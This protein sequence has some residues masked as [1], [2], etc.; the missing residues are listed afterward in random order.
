MGRRTVGLALVGPGSRAAGDGVGKAKAAAA[1]PPKVLVVTSTAGRSDD[2][3]PGR[4]Q[5]RRRRRRVHGHRA[6][7]GRGRRGVHAREPRDLPRGRVPQHGHREPAD[8]RAARRSSR[9]T[10]ARAAVRRHRLGDRDRSVMAVPDRRP[11]HARVRPHRAADGH[12][13]G[14]RPRPR[15]EQVAPAC[16]GS[17]T[18]TG[19][20]SPR[21]SA[22]SRTCSRPWSRTRSARS[23]RAQTLDGIAG[24]TMGANH[25]VSFCKDYQGGR[26]FYTG[27]RQH[28]RGLRRDADHAPEG[29]DQL[30]RRHERPGLQRLRRDGPAQ[31]PADE[32]RLAAEPAGADRLRPAPGRPDPPDGPPRLAAPA[33]RGHGHDHG[34][35]QLR[36]PEPAADAAHL[37]R[38][39][40]RP[41]RPGRRRE[42]RDQQVGLPLLLA[43][44]GHRRQA[45]DGAIVTQTTPTTNPPNTAASEDGVGSVRRLPPALA[46]QVRRGRERP[47]A[48]HRAPSSRSCGSR[49][50]ARS[51]ATSPATSTSTST[52]TCGWSRAT[53]RPRAASTPAAT[54]RSTTRRPTSSRPCASPTRPA[55]RSR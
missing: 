14:L 3:R 53:T 8:G 1:D 31:L 49:R 24:G 4:D 13:E 42:L 19:T 39:R 52:A 7:A 11:R 9:R 37:L 35:R 55:A 36:G 25:P 17:A 43:A 46:L 38:R 48:G 33:R 22:A 23:R 18:T 30:G 10:S 51:A 34:R 5:R 50:T 26:S 28:R 2:R 40:G 54:A 6:R 27:A 21:T 12:G 47:A 29:R 45:S 15:R 16:T 44:D 41:L 20:T 32:D